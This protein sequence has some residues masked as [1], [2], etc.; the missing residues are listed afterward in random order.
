MAFNLGEISAEIKKLTVLNS[1]LVMRRDGLT[2]FYT[3][4]CLSGDGVAADKHR[5]EIHAVLDEMLDCNARLM[6]LSRQIMKD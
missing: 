3:A 1:S 6:H 2:S 5:Q 4:A